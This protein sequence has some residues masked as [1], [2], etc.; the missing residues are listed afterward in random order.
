MGGVRVVGDVGLVVV[1]MLVRVV[2]RAVV[3]IESEVS[4][5]VTY[6]R[7]RTPSSLYTS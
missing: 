1:R 5:M 7:S 6:P 3:M 4:K 2:G